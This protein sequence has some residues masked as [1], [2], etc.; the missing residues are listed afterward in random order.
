MPDI[1][2]A[3]YGSIVLL[4]PGSIA[5]RAWLGENCDGSGYQPFTGGT[6]LWEPR[7]VELIV[8]GVADAGL[9]VEAR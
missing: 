3:D 2:V 7:H 4:R 1:F 8:A 9:V 6:V 5:G